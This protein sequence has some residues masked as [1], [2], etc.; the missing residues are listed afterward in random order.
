MDDERSTEG[1]EPPDRDEPAGPDALAHKLSEMARSLHEAEDPGEVL[2][3]A[4]QAAIDLVPGAWEGSV[5]EVAGRGRVQHKAASGP[6]PARVDAIMSEVREGPCL[7]ALTERK[8]IRVD[9]LRLEERWRRFTPRAVEAG[10]LSMLAFPMI[11]DE[12]TLCALNLYGAE[13]GAFTDESVDV[14]R[15]L[16]AHAAIAYA[17]AQREENL[18]AAI[19]TRDLIGQAV[20]LLME[21]Y[22]I[23]TNP[24]FSTLVRFSRQSNRKLRDVAAELIRDAEAGARK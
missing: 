6:L 24:A 18:L 5:T 13:P 16:A 23:G 7:D 14:G 11:V 4:V 12:D 19:E 17:G 3:E 9:D 21:R 22:S 1:L 8:V 15:L 20:G 2:R 10:A